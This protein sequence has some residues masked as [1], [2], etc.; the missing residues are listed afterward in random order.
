M[1]KASD[2]CAHCLPSNFLPSGH[3]FFSSF[4]A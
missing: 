3:P 1:N 4:E 2:R